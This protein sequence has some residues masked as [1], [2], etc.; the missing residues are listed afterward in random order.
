M[1]QDIEDAICRMLRKL[2]PFRDTAQSPRRPYHT[3]RRALKNRVLALAQAGEHPMTIAR[4]LG[5]SNECIRKVFYR[6]GIPFEDRRKMRQ[7]ARH[8]A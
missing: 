1:T 8:A 3:Q 4:E 2:E 5:C 6:A 7:E